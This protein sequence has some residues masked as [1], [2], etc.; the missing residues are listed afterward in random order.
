VL[1]IQLGVASEPIN[2]SIERQLMTASAEATAPQTLATM[3]AIATARKRIAGNV[4]PALALEAMLVAAVR[5]A[6]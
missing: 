3:D 5:S 1:L 2:L 4:A 6:S